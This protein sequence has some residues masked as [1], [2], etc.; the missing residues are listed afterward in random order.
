MF[1]CYVTFFFF[2]NSIRVLFTVVEINRLMFRRSIA[3][4]KKKKF[5]TG[6]RCE[7]NEAQATEIRVHVGLSLWKQHKLRPHGTPPPQCARVKSSLVEKNIGGLEHRVGVEADAAFV[8]R[9]ALHLRERKKN[10]H[11]WNASQFRRCFLFGLK[12]P[13]PLLRVID[14]QANAARMSSRGTR[15]LRSTHLSAKRAPAKNKKEK[16]SLPSGGESERHTAGSAW[17]RLQ[18]A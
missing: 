9:F 3:K 1:L 10:S 11:N 15:R 12:E 14:S 5:A 13:F 18:P 17:L 7:W 8:L 2:F 6:A 4:K 16:C